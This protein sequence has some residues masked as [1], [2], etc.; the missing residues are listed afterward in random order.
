MSRRLLFGLSSVLCLTAALRAQQVGSVRGVVFD[1]DFAV[2]LEGALVQILE[3]GARTL[4]NDQGNFVLADLQAGSY[5]VL[6]SKDG[7]QSQPTSAVVARGRLTD[8][9]TIELLGEFTDLEEFVVQ[10]ALNL[11]TSSDRGLQIQRDQSAA[12]MDSISRDLMQKAN[13][14]DARDA[15]KLVAGASTQ[16]GKSAVIRGL[17]DRYVAS[18]MNGVLLPSSDEDKRAIELDQFPSSV[19]ESLQ[20]AKTFTPDQQGNASGGAVNILLRGVPEEPLFFNWKVGTSYN[21]QVSGRSDFLTYDDGGVHAFGKSGSQRS[22]QEEGENWEGAVGAT[23]GEAPDNFKWSSSFGG[24]IDLGNGWRAGGLAN[25]FYDRSASFYEDGKDETRILPTVGSQ[26]V[27]QVVQNSPGDPPYITSLLSIDKSVQQVQWG[28]LMTAGIANDD[29]SIS[30]ALLYTRSAEDTVVVAE[31]TAGKE[32]FFP[33]YDPE[34]PLS[35]GYD[36]E[37]AAPYTRQTTLAYLERGTR[38]AQLGGRHR[39]EVFGYGPLRGLELD[40]TVARSNATR[41]TPDRREFGVTWADGTY[42]PFKPAAEFFLGNMQRTFIRIEERSDEYALNL[43][44]PFEVFNGRKGYLKTGIFNDN[45]TRTFRQQT[46]SNFAVTGGSETP[47]NSFDAPFTGGLDWSDNWGNEFHPVTGSDADVNY[48][49][50]QRISATYLMA[51]IPLLEG[52]RLVGG[53]RWENT[54]IAITVDAEEDAKYVPRFAPDGTP[55]F[56]QADFPVTDPNDPAYDPAALALVNPVVEQGD[57]L[58]SIALVY[59]LTDTLT[60]RFSYAETI[61]RQTFKELSPVFQQ[62]YVGGPVFIGEPTLQIADVSNWDARLDWLPTDGSLFS[63]SYF[64]KFI[65]NPIEYV[66]VRLPFS[67]TKPINYPRGTLSGWEVE[68][69]QELGA[70]LPPLEGLAAGGNSTWI[71]SSV[72]LPQDEINRFELF[73]GVKPRTSRDMTGAPEY[74]WN[75]FLTYDI[76]PTGTSIGAFYT[77]T[78]DTLLQ[79]R[80]PGDAGITPP[81]Y[82]RRYDSLSVSLRQQLGRGVQLALGASNLTDATRRQ[83]YRSEFLAEDVTRREYQNGVTYSLSISGVIRF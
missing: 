59:D 29:H 2:P 67:T 20:V 76:A 9:R 66:E 32:Y 70:L 64:K 13:V 10:E 38:T 51:E 27:P 23:T 4:T 34:D 33:G 22:I 83:V 42:R 62:D 39:F 16:N 78:G 46:F 63:V 73:Q 72:R 40:W 1:K 37:E 44:L 79:G 14:S 25:F 68:M 7:Y 49:G 50:K 56:T 43:K 52:M 15:L 81:T 8:L 80:G 35:P 60:A 55:N 57:V 31:D 53:V 18:V 28:G 12:M 11:D 61:A 6:V 54:R 71:D 48:D 69:R 77:V 17:P 65:I 41:D 36:D 45:L 75:A 3:T 24:R 47:P 74:I 58:P 5:T 82:D 19:I 21:D 30:A 26:M